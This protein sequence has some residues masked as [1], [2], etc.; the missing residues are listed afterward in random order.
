MTAL[1]RSFFLCVCGV[2]S[3]E[4]VIVKVAFSSLACRVF[5]FF[6]VYRLEDALLWTSLREMVLKCL[7]VG[8]LL[9]SYSFSA[10]SERIRREDF[11]MTNVSLV[12]VCFRK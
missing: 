3:R 8:P 2:A 11:S 7:C 4:F 5:F 1:L 9:S 10:A 6:F 12:T